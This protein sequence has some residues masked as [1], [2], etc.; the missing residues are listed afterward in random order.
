MKISQKH[1]AFFSKL[2]QKKPMDHR[3]SL[4]LRISFV[5]IGFLSLVWFFVCVIPRPNRAAYPCQRAALPLGTS[6]VIWLLG[7]IGSA[8]MVRKVKYYCRRFQ[9]VLAGLCVAVSITMALVVVG[10]ENK[11]A[12]SA[13]NPIPNEPLGV[14]RGIHPGRVVWIHDPDATDWDGPDTGDGHWWENDNTS[15]ILTDR[16]AKTTN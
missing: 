6:F 16:P 2:I 4:W 13:D 9:Y 7:V 12:S 3:Y 8:A 15:L 11:P 5:F 14:A 10:G 1:I